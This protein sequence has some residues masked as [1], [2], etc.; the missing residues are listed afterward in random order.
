MFLHQLKYFTP[1]DSDDFDFNK[2][3]II[4]RL[5]S[6]I[7]LVFGCSNSKPVDS[8]KLTERGGLVYNLKP[9]SLF[10]GKGVKIS[11]TPFN[12]KAVKH[13]SSGE[14]QISSNL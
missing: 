3:T 12:G 2:G 14:V 4:K 6:I 10:H 7:L 11:D 9:N 1:T 13:Y 5:L 8:S